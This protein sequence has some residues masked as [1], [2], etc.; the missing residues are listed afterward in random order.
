MNALF[1]QGK[2]DFRAYN[3]LSG[4]K[5]RRKRRRFNRKL[6][7]IL[8]KKSVLAYAIATWT[9]H[10]IS[11]SD[12]QN[13]HQ[14]AYCKAR[15]KAL[16][17]EKITSTNNVLNK[18]SDDEENH[19]DD[20]IEVSAEFLQF[21]KTNAKFKEDARREREIL[22][23]NLESQANDL[24]RTEPD[25]SEPMSIEQCQNMYGDK[26]QQICPL[27]ML[28]TNHYVKICEKYKPA[29]WPNI[30]LNL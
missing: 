29:L 6:Q 4:K 5:R 2:T 28:L 7:K 25:I 8:N 24:I 14:L 13:Q 20:N 17:Y 11:A 23:S 1:S 15:A 9:E 30:P 12:W 21:L 27:E 19:N 26:W 22:K 18:N 3:I 16:Q 10:Y